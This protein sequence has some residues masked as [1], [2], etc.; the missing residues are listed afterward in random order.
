MKRRVEFQ[1]EDGKNWKSRAENN[2]KDMNAFEQDVS[3]EIN[4]VN[5]IINEVQSLASNTELGNGPK[6]D[7]ALREA[8]E[9][10]GKIKQVC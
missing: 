8:Q 3:K 7:N 1:E 9:I 10:L 6:I 5:T 4:L 2:L